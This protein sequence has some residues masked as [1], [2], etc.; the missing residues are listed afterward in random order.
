MKKSKL[1]LV[2][3]VS[4][5]C[6]MTSTI[7]VLAASNPANKTKS[8][9]VKASITAQPKETV[10][11][12]SHGNST[13]AKEHAKNKRITQI[14]KYVNVTEDQV[15]KTIT[16]TIGSETVT[17]QLVSLKKVDK[18]DTTKSSTEISDTDTTTN[19]TTTPTDSTTTN[20]STTQT[21]STTSITQATTD[22][23]TNTTGITTTVN[24]SST[25]VPPNSTSTTANY[26]AKY[27]GYTTN[28][29]VKTEYNKVN[30]GPVKN[31]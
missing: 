19:T 22:T 30:R 7:S 9:P 16:F 14:K 18:T 31:K 4:T 3:M 20:N 24:T 29:N 10:K 23:T 8:T 27:V 21:D 5:V 28:K 2:S 17:L 12:K 11:Q 13:N 25:V 15:P 1:A 6:I 26:V